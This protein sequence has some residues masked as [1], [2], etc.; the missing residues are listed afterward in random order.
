VGEE[1]ERRSDRESLFLDDL[2][3]D[4]E[5]SFFAPGEE[6]GRIEGRIRRRSCESAAHYGRE[7]DNPSS[8]A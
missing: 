7:S 8:P 2:S 4:N 1:D 3:G 5:G 6:G